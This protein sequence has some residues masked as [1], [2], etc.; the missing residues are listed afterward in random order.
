MKRKK[1]EPDCPF[2]HELQQEWVEA[3]PTPIIILEQE[4]PSYTF[5]LAPIVID[6]DPT[7]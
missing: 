2:L 7:P 5:E 4:D 1:P 6:N 3:I